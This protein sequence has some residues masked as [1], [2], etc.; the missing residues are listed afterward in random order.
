MGVSD[1]WVQPH[2]QPKAARPV[3]GSVGQGGSS[4]A[5]NIQKQGLIYLR[6][7][8]NSQS[9]AKDALLIPLPLPP[10]CWDCAGIADIDCH[11][12]LMWYWGQNR[13]L[14]MQ[15]LYQSSYIASPS[16]LSSLHL[17]FPIFKMG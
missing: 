16:F 17:S 14:C 2:L 7:A 4:P 11:T 13:E 8:L 1:H 6:L 15:I 3:G 5:C 12:W 9:V 10:W